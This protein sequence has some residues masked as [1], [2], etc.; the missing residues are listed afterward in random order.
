MWQTNDR[1]LRSPLHFKPWR[2]APIGLTGGGN[3]HI[4][5]HVDCS[6]AIQQLSN[7]PQQSNNKTSYCRQLKMSC[8]GLCLGVL[9]AAR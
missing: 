2:L 9:A 6:L 7:L 5:Q 3:E 4:P 8:L 1:K